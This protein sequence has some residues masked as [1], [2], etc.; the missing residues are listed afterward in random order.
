[1]SLSILHTRSIRREE[2]S[3]GL[4]FWCRH[5]L[6]DACSW[7]VG[8]LSQ[9]QDSFRFITNLRLQ[10]CEAKTSPKLWLYLSHYLKI[11]KISIPCPIPHAANSFTPCNEA[12]NDWKGSGFIKYIW[13]HSVTMLRTCAFLV[14]RMTRN[15]KTKTN[16]L[17]Q[18][19]DSEKRIIWWYLF[20]C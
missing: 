1:M 14:I 19:F 6:I 11:Y 4:N 16:I 10:I 8:V 20:L 12:K 5:L 2:P 9:T 18:N 3:L 17:M 15:D 13:G 7:W